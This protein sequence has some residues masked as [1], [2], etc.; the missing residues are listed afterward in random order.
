MAD[1]SPPALTPVP[2][3]SDT[4]TPYDR[5]HLATYLKLIDADAMNVDWKETARTVLS[6]DP[7]THVKTAHRVYTAHLARARWMTQTGYRLLLK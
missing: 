7:D 2:P 3:N 4:L 5:A 6:L 1:P